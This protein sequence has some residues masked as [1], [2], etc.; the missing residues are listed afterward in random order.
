MRIE[1]TFSFIIK[2]IIS[3][4]IKLF[5][6][7]KW[8]K[9]NSSEYREFLKLFYLC[10]PDSVQLQ[11]NFSWAHS[12]RESKCRT[13]FFLVCCFSLY[14]NSN[15]AVRFWNMSKVNVYLRI[16]CRFRLNVFFTMFTMWRN[17]SF[18]FPFQSSCSLSVSLEI[19]FK[20]KCGLW[21]L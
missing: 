12:H 6:S 8:I 3:L 15:H 20:D 17:N 2:T 5:L 19:Q 14:H 13:N 7:T 18:Q 9:I 16:D 4:A 1:S 11:F 21:T 10:N